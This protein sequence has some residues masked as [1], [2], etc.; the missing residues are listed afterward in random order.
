M[1]WMKYKGYKELKETDG[2]KGESI[3]ILLEQEQIWEQ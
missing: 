1:E 2:K 3:F